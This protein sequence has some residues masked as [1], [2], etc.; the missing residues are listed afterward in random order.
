MNIYYVYIN[1]HT[2]SIYFENVYMYTFILYLNVFNIN[3]QYFLNIIMRVF[4]FIINV[5]S[6]HTLCKQK[7]VFWMRFNYLTELVI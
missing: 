3:I 7:L 6:M 2:C 1:T 4:G 5:H